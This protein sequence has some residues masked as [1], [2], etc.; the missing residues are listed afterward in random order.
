MKKIITLLVALSLGL[1][2]SNIQVE[3]A[4]ARA[5][6]PGLPNSASFMSIK[7]I[8]DKDIALIN[9]KSSIANAV[10][11]H[12]HDMKDGKMMMYQVPKIDIKANTSTVLKPGGFHIMFIGLKQKPL[13]EG[14]NVDLELHFSNGE[15]VALE[16]PVKSVMGGMMKKHHMKNRNS[17]HEKCDLSK[18]KA[19]NCNHD[20]C[21]MKM[22]NGS[23]G[24]GKCGSNMKK[25]MSCGQ[26]KCGSN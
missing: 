25:G 12:T 20:K 9:A 11:L 21:D 26:G 8:S 17:G 14:Q 4:Y 6:P 2:A 15:K 24:Q 16:V 13:K 22:K 10:E 23:C 18:K 1:L 3:D 5:T 19:N 7:N